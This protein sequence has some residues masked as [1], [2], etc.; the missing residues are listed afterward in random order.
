M[1]CTLVLAYIYACVNQC[2]R[3]CLA[4]CVWVSRLSACSG[5]ILASFE[6]K[7]TFLSSSHLNFA[8][9]LLTMNK[10]A[11]YIYHKYR[12]TWINDSTSRLRALTAALQTVNF[13]V[14]DALKSAAKA[15]P[16]S[17]IAYRLRLFLRRA[18]HVCS[19]YNTIY[20]CTAHVCAVKFAA[21]LRN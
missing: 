20:L 11:L 17:L 19:A 18:F 15:A 5:I 9:I 21:A 14:R 13:R 8:R 6:Y 1:C 4:K 2:M 7:Y 3:A 10:A 16:H 12:S